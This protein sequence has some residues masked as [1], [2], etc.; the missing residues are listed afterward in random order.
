MAFVKAF[1]A[2]K[3]NEAWIGVAS[4]LYGNKWREAL[5]PDDYNNDEDER[6]SDGDEDSSDG[7]LPDH[8]R[9]PTIQEYV[10]NK[11]YPTQNDSPTL[12]QNQ[13]RA[14]FFV[15][16][17]V[18]NLPEDDT[19]MLDDSDDDQSNSSEDN[20]TC[21]DDINSETG[22]VVL[23]QAE[24]KAIVN[25]L[26]SQC[27]KEVLTYLAEHV[28]EPF[29]KNNPSNKDLIEW[30][31]ASNSTRNYLFYKA[32]G[33]RSMIE[34]RHL[35]LETGQKTV[36]HMIRALA[37]DSCAPLVP[38]GGRDEEAPLSASSALS[39]VERESLDAA[40]KAILER[41]FLPH[42]KGKFREHCS[43]GHRLEIPILKIGFKLHMK[44]WILR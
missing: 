31:T 42:K 10:T 40:T 43:L 9:P 34:A 5:L 15:Q 30:L 1:P 13:R 11:R 3:E 23:T 16:R 20:S 44:V 2:F 28:H 7:L 22:K 38:V 36:A 19:S 6:P 8:L 21:E 39:V 14:Y 41:S 37:E 27:R 33:L 18:F 4:Y 32:A 29:R 26:Q 35:E 12:L 24:A 25:G 17:Y